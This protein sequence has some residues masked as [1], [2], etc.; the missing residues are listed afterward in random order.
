MV[1]EH[2]RKQDWLYHYRF[3]EGIYNSF[4]GLVRRAAYMD[5]H[6]KAFSIFETNYV[7]LGLAYREFFPRLK[8]E[9]GNILIELINSP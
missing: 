7:A 9:A 1:F 6:R 4:A 3:K 2:M 8:T 5:D